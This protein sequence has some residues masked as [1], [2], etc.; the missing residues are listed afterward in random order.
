MKMKGS[1]ETMR[2]GVI[3]SRRQRTNAKQTQLEAE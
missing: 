1:E 2:K 3:G